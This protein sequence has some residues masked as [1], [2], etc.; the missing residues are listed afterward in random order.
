M[1]EYDGRAR[2]GEVARGCLVGFWPEVNCLLRRRY[3]PGSGEPD[4]NI[5]VSL[6]RISS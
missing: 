1:G 5:T 4:Y 6:E 3:D 2:I